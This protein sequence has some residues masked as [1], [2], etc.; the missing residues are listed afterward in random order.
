MYNIL[1]GFPW[2]LLVIHENVQDV[3][4]RCRKDRF[5]YHKCF[6]YDLLDILPL[7]GL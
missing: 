1:T 2:I 5:R 4:L 6:L 7:L 3:L